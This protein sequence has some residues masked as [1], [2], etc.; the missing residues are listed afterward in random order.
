[1]KRIFS[2]SA[3][4]AA[5]LVSSLPVAAQTAPSTLVDP[6]APDAVKCRKLEI[7]GSLVRKQRICMTNAQWAKSREQQTRDGRD[8]VERSRSGMNSAQ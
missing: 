7:T 6:N 5:A 8:L 1:M 4:I 3:V 2:G